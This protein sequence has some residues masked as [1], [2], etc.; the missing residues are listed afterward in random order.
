MKPVYITS[1]FVC[2]SRRVYAPFQSRPADKMGYLC[3][4][5]VTE[6]RVDV[7]DV[8]KVHEAVDDLPN[9]AAEMHFAKVKFVCAILHRL[10][11]L[12]ADFGDDRLP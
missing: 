10:A 11:V 9:K 8:G 4:R 12:R 1:L 6:D 2:I 3:N 5:E 7:V